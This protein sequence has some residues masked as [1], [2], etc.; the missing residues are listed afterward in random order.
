MRSFFCNCTHFLIVLVLCFT[1]IERI[2]CIGNASSA[3]RHIKYSIE[4]L[5]SSKFEMKTSLDID[6]D[7]CKSGNNLEYFKVTEHLAVGIL[8]TFFLNL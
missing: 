1:S 6:M 5:L 3:K 2:D 7:P 8:L 4:D